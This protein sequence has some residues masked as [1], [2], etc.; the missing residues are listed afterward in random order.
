[1]ANK[2]IIKRGLFADLPT[3]WLTVWEPYYTTDTHQ[4]FIADSAT[5]MK[6]Y[7]QAWNFAVLDGNGKLNNSVL[8]ALSITNVTVVNS[9]SEQLALAAEL[10]DV[11]VRTDENKTYI[12]NGWTAGD[13]T[14][15]TLL[16][17]PTDSVTSVNWH[18]GIIVLDPD[19]LDDTSTTNKF[20]TQAEKDA[21]AL[22][23]NKMDIGATI[24][25]GT[26]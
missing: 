16:L 10:W 5:T 20:V 11:V 14:D 24:D 6:E 9:Q 21:I 4:F 26:F 3:S 8:P 7:A 13:M 19:D 1:M 15:Y 22:I 25:W 12:H 23:P 2:I 18:T 17:T